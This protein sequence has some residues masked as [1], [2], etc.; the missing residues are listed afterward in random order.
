MK[1]PDEEGF[2][3]APGRC[4]GDV[5]DADATGDQRKCQYLLNLRDEPFLRRK[6]RD[7]GTCYEFNH[8]A[9]GW[10]RGELRLNFDVVICHDI[11]AISQL[12]A[13][14]DDDLLRLRG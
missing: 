11:K 8:M 13:S 7:L 4:S 1:L 5:C 6:Q 3:G 10:R 2:L 14:G 12:E 9:A